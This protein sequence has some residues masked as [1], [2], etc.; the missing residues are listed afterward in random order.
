MDFMEKCE[1]FAQHIYE[2]TDKPNVPIEDW[3]LCKICDKTFAEI[4]EKKKTLSDKKTNDSMEDGWQ[5]QEEDVKEHLKEFMKKCE[6]E[7]YE[8]CHLHLED[9][10]LFLEEE[11]GKELME[12]I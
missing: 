3:L 10:E 7:D 6:K 8:D 12:E 1:K 5:Y 2:H 11:M 9:V 4:V